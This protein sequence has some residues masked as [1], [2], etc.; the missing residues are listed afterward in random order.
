MYF[1]TVLIWICCPSYRSPAELLEEKILISLIMPEIIGG[2]YL[3]QNQMVTSNVA[4]KSL[5]IVPN[6]AKKYKMFNEILVSF[7]V[8]FERISKPSG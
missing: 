5:I 8:Q 1:Y 2:Y 3:N 7:P 4:G 6:G